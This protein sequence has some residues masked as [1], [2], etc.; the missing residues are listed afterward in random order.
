MLK[1]RQER[2]RRGWSLVEVCVRTRIESTNISKIE[3]GLLPAYPG[4]RQRLAD[5]F[6]MP[7]DVLFEKVTDDDHKRD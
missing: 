2:L 6:D 3:R 5:A 4:W 7:E 1:L